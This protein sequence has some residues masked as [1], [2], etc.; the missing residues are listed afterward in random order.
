MESSITNDD[1]FWE[2]G[3]IFSRH[4]TTSPASQQGQFG[5]YPGSPTSI[6]SMQRCSRARRMRSGRMEKTPGRRP[7]A[8]TAPTPSSSPRGR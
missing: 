1:L 8:P 7:A 2:T 4:I 5:L 3:P 6:F